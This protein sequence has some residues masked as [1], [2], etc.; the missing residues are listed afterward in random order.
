[1][2]VIELFV[3]QML[4]IDQ[5]NSKNNPRGVAASNTLIITQTVDN[6]QYLQSVGD[7]LNIGQQVEV[8]KSV[9]CLA[10]E[11]YLEISDRGRKF[12]SQQDVIQILALWQLARTV[13]F[14]AVSQTLVISQAVDVVFCTPGTNTL[15]LTQSVSY[16]ITRN[17]VCEQTL[18]INSG[19]SGYKEDKNFYSTELPTITG[20]NTPEGP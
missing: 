15:V 1:M 20:P 14:E 8:H 18:V 10:V 2:A 17:L 6:H 7:F 13:E 11:Q 4:V 5:S 19:C 12:N 9:I 16:T 3:D